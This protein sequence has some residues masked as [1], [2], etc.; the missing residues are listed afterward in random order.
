MKFSLLTLF[1]LPI[2]AISCGCGEPSVQWKEG[3][4]DDN[5]KAC[6]EL[7]LKNVPAGSRIW[8]S[9]IPQRIKMADDAPVAINY[10]KGN[11]YY[12]DVP[13]HEGKELSIKYISEPLPRKSWAP[14]GFYLQTA[15]KPD[16]EL[17]VEYT[18]IERTG[19][20]PGAEWFAKSFQPL[21]TDIIPS[22]KSVS[23]GEGQ[24]TKPDYNMAKIEVLPDSAEKPGWYR[25]T[26]DENGATIEA[27]ERDGFRNAAI[28]YSL[29]PN[30]LQ[31]VVIE[32]WPDFQY[33][34][35]MLDVA[36]SFL[37][38]DDVL[39]L[40]DYL[41]R[42]KVNK[43]HLHIVD[44]EG[45]ALE[46]P[47]LPELTSYGARHA[48]PVV[49]DDKSEDN[50]AKAG[51]LWEPDGIMP[52]TNG[53]VNEGLFY[54]QEEF[55]EIIRYA[56]E[57]NI[58]VIPEFDAP[59]HSRAAIRSME[60]YERRTGDNSFRLATPGDPSEYSS[61]QGFDDNVL[62]VQLPG[63]YKF[64]ECIFDNVIGMY[65]DAEVPLEA[66]HIGGDEV[67]DGAWAGHSHLEMKD[68][69][70][71]RML[72]IAENK[73][74]KLAGWQEITQNIRPETAERL[75][76]QLVFINVWSTRGKNIELPYIL[77]NEGWP[78]VLSNVQ[79]TYIDL[80]YSDGP[81]ETG[82]TWGGYVD[83]R[84]TFAL[85]PFNLYESV[86][87]KDV[88]TPVENLA[89]ASNGRIQL[90][91]PWNIKGVQVQL[92]S[93]NLRNFGAFT[94][95]IFPK[96]IGAFERAWNAHPSW[97]DNDAFKRDFDRFY[98][99]IAAK[100][101]PYYDQQGIRYKNR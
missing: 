35:F 5:G 95:S 47:E 86:R 55:K 97:T 59:G 7:V 8:F 94:Y 75:K 29:L 24:V 34:G 62:D 38:K 41:E 99:I 54:T 89:D 25:I 46:I 18:F 96:A 56:W 49:K 61:A 70:I 44:D 22:V 2:L 43:L 78:V 77:A 13:E 80:A 26:I 16:K 100:E 57:R 65:A 92:W 64:M 10:Y 37:P 53:K 88:D 39:K 33:R 60:A 76:K 23:Y 21:V 93:E 85:Q 68:L 84:K 91:Q 73:N 45:W 6:H 14:E 40:I 51:E 3:A 31:P 28:T 71:N 83:E 63:V 1:V 9:R 12:F 11:S 66:I 42:Y 67:P 50:F 19:T 69:F 36:R 27:A 98:S 20:E 4:A 82:L 52:S 48:L 101:F 58:A 87:W 90:T 72:D 81:D 74:V 32:D 15:G 17:P 30:Q 79:N